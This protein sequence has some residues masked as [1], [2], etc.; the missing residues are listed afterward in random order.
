MLTAGIVTAALLAL[1]ALAPLA[2]AASDPV[3][4]GSATVTLNNAF[5]KGLKKKGVKTSAV[6]PAKLKGSKLTLKVTGGS[7]DP[8]TGKGTVNL[9]GGLKFKAGKKSTTV[10]RLV[11]NVTKGPIGAKL[12]GNVGGKNAVFATITG[13]S[14]ARNGFGVNLTIKQFKLSGKAAGQLNKKLGLKGKKAAFKGNK[15]MGSGKTEV[16]PATVGIVPTGS[17]TLEIALSA[18]EK[19]TKLKSP[20]TLAPVAPTTL[21]GLKASFPLAP[22]G[23]I[24]PSLTSGTV[25]TNGGLELSQNLGPGGITHLTLGNVWYDLA[26][27]SATVEVTIANATTPAL[28]LGNLG[29]VSIADLNVTGATVKVDPTT[30]TISIENASATL[31]A[32]TAATLNQVFAEPVGEKDIFK[33][34]DP[35]GTFSFTAQ[36]E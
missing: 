14:S 3:G 24:S 36:T 35:L 32:L 16:Q 29:R 34:G 33:A 12:T 22:E 28:N 19:L 11:L 8:A 9:G 25:K 10:K 30:R 26:T 23:T 7:I 4:S 13:F 15:V 18:V 2:S 17:A 20:V 1:L 27:K 31:Q 21:V 6:S 5:V